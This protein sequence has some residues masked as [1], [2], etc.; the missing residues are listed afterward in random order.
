MK[1][2][3]NLIHISLKGVNL[4][5]VYKYCQKEN[6]A[7]YNIDRK[8]YKNIE[9]DINYKD[10]KHFYELVKLQNYACI[11][12][13]TQGKNKISNFVKLRFGL[14]FGAFLFIFF[15]IFS[16]FMIFDIKIYGNSYVDSSKII[17]VLKTYNITVG[18]FVK[19][20]DFN[21]IETEITNNIED[22]SLCS[23][24]KKGTT[25]VVNVKEKLKNEEMQFI[26]QGKD[27]VATQNFTL[28]ELVVANGT[29]K[30]KVGDSVKAGDIIVAG[31]VLDSYGKKINCKASANIKAKTW[32]SASEIYKKELEINVRTGKKVIN[33]YLD[34]FGVKYPI[35]N[36]KNEFEFFEEELKE[37]EIKNNFLPFKMYTTTYYEITKQVVEQDFEKDRQKILEKCQKQAYSKVVNT[38]LISNIFDTI[39]EEKDCFVITS[40]IEVNLEF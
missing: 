4:N 28:T 27:I 30:K 12:S 25:I 21:F 26:S 15:N 11:V 39:T 6:I 17:Q 37:T 1:N 18:K 32:F 10:K 9:F 14:I 35:K 36:T 13:Q 23:I 3:L 29:A 7:L 20:Q 5:R 22:I 34:L 33:S 2:K 24:M 19:N 8:D 40:Y 38:S 31:Y 16:S